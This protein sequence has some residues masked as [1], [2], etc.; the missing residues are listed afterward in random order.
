[1]LLPGLLFLQAR[2]QKIDVLASI[3]RQ[4]FRLTAGEFCK[5]DEDCPIKG[6]TC[7]LSW[8]ENECW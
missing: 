2:E 4:V 5:T 7:H 1:M 8:P 6:E 3:F